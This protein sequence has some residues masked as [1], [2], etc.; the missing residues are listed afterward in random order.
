[1]AQLR[2]L[3]W[4]AQRE[5]VPQQHN[6]HGPMSQGLTSHTIITTT[7]PKQAAPWP[8]G[9]QQ[10]AH[11]RSMHEAPTHYQRH[12]IPALVAGPK[13]HARV[14]CSE[15]TRPRC[16]TYVHTG[17]CPRASAWNG[18]ISHA[19]R[20]NPCAHESC[21]AGGAQCST[22]CSTLPLLQENARA[23]TRPTLLAGLG[24]ECV[25]TVITVASACSLSQS[26]RSRMLVSCTSVSTFLAAPCPHA[27]QGGGQQQ[28]SA[29][30]AC[31]MR[32]GLHTAWQS[33]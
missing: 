27:R 5:P 28:L 9:R 7:P 22:Y 1:M 16:S 19:L 3:T 26:S 14:G 21:S 17:P 2:K 32:L 20:R 25:A 24:V 31:C 4:A 8:R 30:G 15:G 10:H 12:P 29:S 13:M 18:I 6:T 33:A 23:S 11:A